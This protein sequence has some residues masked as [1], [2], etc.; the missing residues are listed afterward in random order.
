MP[1]TVNEQILS[2]TIR[3]A[4]MVERFKV[5]EIHRLL[6]M[7]DDDVYSNLMAQLAKDLPR[8]HTANRMVSPRSAQRYRDM[9]RDLRAISRDG[10]RTTRT[11]S[12]AQLLD[13]GRMEGIWQGASVT[14]AMPVSI[15]FGLPTAGM[16]QQIVNREVIQGAPLTQWWAGLARDTSRQVEQAINS[17][18][19]NGESV[20]QI[21]RR[22]RGTR[23]FPGAFG[24]S[25]RNV[26][27]VVRTSITHV[28]AR[29]REESFA[30][31][32]D[33]IKGYQYVATLD[34]RTTDICA[35]IDGQVFPV[36]QGPRPPLHINCRS[37]VIPIMKSW[38]EMGLPF[39]DMTDTTR[40]SMN[41]Q[42]PARLFYPE[43]L[44]G[45][46]VAIQNEALGVG[47]AKLFRQGMPISR[48]VTPQGRPLTLAQLEAIW[49]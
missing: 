21:V 3:R 9:V 28:S 12:K 31:N 36:G 49:N 19:A 30:A 13:F 26:Q 22:I 18:I 6:S 35:S 34:A 5:S 10:F 33:I 43:W 11:A 25:R 15:S 14:A 45:Q 41:G 46:S 4:I 8:I 2:D 44:R 29:A 16:L 47:R 40:A 23:S 20:D 32:S 17:G 39:K 42:V 1:L 37:T 48:F 24:S 27:S 38:K 7:L